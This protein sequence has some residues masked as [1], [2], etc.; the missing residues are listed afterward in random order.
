MMEVIVAEYAGACYGVNR[1]LKKAMQ[2]AHGTKKVYTLGPLIHNPQVVQELRDMGIE[3][4]ATLDDVERGA[5]LVIRSHGVP[6]D[7]IDAA[8]E[9]GLE[10]VDATCPHVSKAHRAAQSLHDDGY[11]VVVVGEAGHPEVEGICAYAG[12]NVIVANAASDLPS[13]LPSRIGVVVQTTQSAQALQEVVDALK[14]RTEDLCV[15]NT[16][17]FATTQR[18]ESAAELASK[19][20]VMLVVG[21]RNSGNTRRLHEICKSICPRSYHVEL[22]EEIDPE[23]FTGCAKVGV[24]AGASTPKIQ[25]DAVIDSLKDIT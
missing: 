10:V 15:K 22:P 12:E 11:F 8:K 7:T 24:T 13:K 17:C 9:R 5:I 1:A 6:P 2:A 3:T 18:Q 19:V 23:W 14:D 21:G 4:A 20:D 25:I 16:I